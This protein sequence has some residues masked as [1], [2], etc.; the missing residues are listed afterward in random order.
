MDGSRWIRLLTPTFTRFIYNSLLW[1][2]MRN[3]VYETTRSS[4]RD[5]ITHIFFSTANIW[6]IPAF[7]NKSTYPGKAIVRCLSALALG[8]ETETS[9]T[10]SAKSSFV[11]LERMDESLGPV[12]SQAKNKQNA[13]E[14]DMMEF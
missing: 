5:P 2:V 8:Q 7:S 14:I 1:A 4:I 9:E 13:Y 10:N 11:K 6:E 12:W 3:M